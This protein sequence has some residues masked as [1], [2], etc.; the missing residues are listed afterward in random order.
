MQAD[1]H[2]IL[3]EVDE[4]V[5]EYELH[6][7]RSVMRN[8][9]MWFYHPHDL[10]QI[11]SDM[12]YLGDQTEQDDQRGPGRGRSLYAIYASTVLM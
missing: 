10:A 12:P 7:I 3:R 8:G 5:T 9:A 11:E 4:F 6:S 1:K 2:R